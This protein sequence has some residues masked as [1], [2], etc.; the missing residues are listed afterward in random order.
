MRNKPIKIISI[1]L[2]SLL[3]LNAIFLLSQWVSGYILT[4]TNVPDIVDAYEQAGTLPNEVT[5][6]TVYNVTWWSNPF[7]ISSLI[8]SILLTIYIYRIKSRVNA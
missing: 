6:S 4:V 2:I 5:F 7:V 1:F 3:S 8:T